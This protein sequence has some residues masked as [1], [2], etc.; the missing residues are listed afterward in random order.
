M[1][2]QVNVLKAATIPAVL[3]VLLT[4][5]GWLFDRSIQRFE[6]ISFLRYSTEVGPT[7]EGMATFTL[8]IENQS[9][10]KPFTNVDIL[11]ECA[12]QVPCF[13]ARKNST[14][15]N[16]NLTYVAV[17][18]VAIAPRIK[19][20]SQTSFSQF[21]VPALPI[22]ARARFL[23]TLTRA[24]K[25]PSVIFRFPDNTDGRV[26][27]FTGTNTAAWAAA[28]YPT[29]LFIILV[30]L[31][32]VTTGYLIWLVCTSGEQQNDARTET[33]RLLHGFGD[34]APR[35]DLDSGTGSG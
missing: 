26:L 33:I 15:A 31:G 18:P 12:D 7:R 4:A 14:T 11:I 35:G 27:P 34:D 25:S 19:D 28:N 2:D 30:L 24:D 6:T 3:T 22:G 13:E 8:E 9:A 21:V 5:T 17:P 32:L 16:R 20:D 29:V 23:Y 10:A 1:G